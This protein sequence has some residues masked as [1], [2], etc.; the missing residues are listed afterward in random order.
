MYKVLRHGSF[1]H[2]RGGV[3]MS[4]RGWKQKRNMFLSSK[5]VISHIRN[6][7]FN[8]LLIHTYTTDI[9]L[10]YC[11]KMKNLSRI[12]FCQNGTTLFDKMIIESPINIC[13]ILGPIVPK[14]PGTYVL[15]LK[16]C[17]LVDIYF[18]T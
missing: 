12:S 5:Y 6:T 15:Y 1:R 4:F 14:S 11:G 16:K 2:V 18:F 9:F 10:K 13:N 3:Q 17:L 7:F 8:T